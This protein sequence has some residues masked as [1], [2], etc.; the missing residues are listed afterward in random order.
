MNTTHKKPNHDPMQ[1]APVIYGYE[2]GFHS[3][4]AYRVTTK[5]RE[6]LDLYAQLDETHEQ[7]A[8][9][10]APANS[11]LCDRIIYEIATHI[12]QGYGGPYEAVI[13]DREGYICVYA[14]KNHEWWS[15]NE[16]L[17][18]QL[19]RHYLQGMRALFDLVQIE[20]VSK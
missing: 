4:S 7:L 1:G 2:R 8:S 3:I 15:S 12:Q 19:L 5:N 11:K 9:V 13:V 6:D 18:V 16:H 14:P 10:N 20:G 17:C